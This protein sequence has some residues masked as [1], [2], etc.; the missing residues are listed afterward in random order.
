MSTIQIEK[1]AKKRGSIVDAKALQYLETNGLLKSKKRNTQKPAKATKSNSTAE[2]TSTSQTPAKSKPEKK[3][4]ETFME[5]TMRLLR[6]INQPIN[7]EKLVQRCIAANPPKS[8]RP[9]WVY[10]DI[11][12]RLVAE[13]KLIVDKSKGRKRKDH[14]VTLP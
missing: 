14:T 5:T 4:R 3:K 10:N 6:E 8:K 12:R 13:N 7:R 2:A 11:I 9:E 1:P